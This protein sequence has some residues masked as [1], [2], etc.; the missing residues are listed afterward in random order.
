MTD[1]QADIIAQADEAMQ[2][3]EAVLSTAVVKATQAVHQNPT[4]ANIKT[5]EAAEQA[6]SDCRARKAAEKKPEAQRFK[7]IREV[8]TYLQA[9]GWKISE[10]KAY[11]DKRLI[12]CQRDGSYIARDVDEYA[13][14]Y[15]QRLDGTDSEDGLGTAKLQEEIA[16]LKQKHEQ[17]RR[18]NEIEAGKWIRRSR[19]ESMLAERAAFLCS[20]LDT[21]IHNFMPRLV[22]MCGG[23]SDAVSEMIAFASEEKEK[24]LDR[25]AQPV[26]FMAPVVAE[27]DEESESDELDI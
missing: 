18:R 19:V 16:I 21:F 3:M 24:W 2:D 25:Y 8:A 6:L 1:A 12:K 20:D 14:R 13:D 27:E 23:N 4:S 17:I 7:N 5:M 11:D 9:A 22:E 10:R 26:P 15:L